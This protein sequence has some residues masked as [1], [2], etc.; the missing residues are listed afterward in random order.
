M[1]KEGKSFASVAEN[2]SEDK[3]RQGGSMGWMIRGS[4][5]GPFQG[6]FSFSKVFD[7]FCDR[8]SLYA[9]TKFGR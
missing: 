9:A 2:Y 1:L 8:C 5:V 7:H 3:A 4:M 6:G